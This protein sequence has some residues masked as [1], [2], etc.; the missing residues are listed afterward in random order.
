MTNGQPYPLRRASV[1]DPLPCRDVDARL[2]RQ[3]HFFRCGL[4]HDGAMGTGWVLDRENR[5]FISCCW[6]KLRISG[7]LGSNKVREHAQYFRFF[8]RERENRGLAGG[9]SISNPRA[10]SCGRLGNRLGRE[11]NAK[12]K[13]T[14]R[15]NARS[16]VAPLGATSCFSASSQVPAIHSVC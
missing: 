16:L 10:T 14:E 5:A 15:L 12:E 11:G 3:T 8:G 6:P 13:G 4:A 9:E 1:D 2:P 7:A